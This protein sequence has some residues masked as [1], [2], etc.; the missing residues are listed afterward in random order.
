MGLLTQE[1]NLTSKKLLDLVNLNQP[2]GV[3]RM[4]M[5]LNSEGTG[6]KGSQNIKMDKKCLY[7]STNRHKI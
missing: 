3:R 6:P 1:R 7:G 2:A 4:C 5:G